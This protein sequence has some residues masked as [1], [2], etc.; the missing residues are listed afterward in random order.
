MYGAIIYRHKIFRTKISADSPPTRYLHLASSLGPV[1]G[2]SCTVKTRS[3][4]YGSQVKVLGKVLKRPF[5][6]CLH[7]KVDEFSFSKSWERKFP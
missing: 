4:L 1:N 2:S 3:L 5:G 7:G 6:E